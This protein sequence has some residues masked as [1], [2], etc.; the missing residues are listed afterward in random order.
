MA[1]QFVA[2]HIASDTVVVFGKKSCPFCQRALDLLKQIN[3]KSGHFKYID[4]T[5]QKNMDD[6]QDYLMQLTGARTV[7]RIFI[8][9]TCIGGFTDLDAL[10]NS[11]ELSVMLQKIGAL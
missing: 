1:E 9:E 3:I 8:G 11:G 10:N 6:I 4:L 5:S 2:S 7:P